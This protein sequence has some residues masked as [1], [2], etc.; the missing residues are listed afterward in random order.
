MLSA[1]IK[2][3]NTSAL[4]AFSWTC[5][6]VS[7]YVSVFRFFVTYTR[8]SISLCL[9]YSSY[10]AASAENVAPLAHGRVSTRL[11]FPTFSPQSPSACPWAASTTTRW[12][13]TQKS[14]FSPDPSF[15]IVIRCLFVSEMPCPPQCLVVIPRVSDLAASRFSALL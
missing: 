5:G 9:H 13:L 14:P 11:S 7:D 6:F 15:Q 4:S 10:L 1:F 3:L 12:Q 2:L 8:N